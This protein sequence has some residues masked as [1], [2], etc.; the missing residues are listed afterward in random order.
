MPHGQT[1]QHTSAATSASHPIQ[2]QS[3]RASS[4]SLFQSG[5]SPHPTAHSGGH[6]PKPCVSPVLT[7]DACAP[8]LLKAGSE[9]RW[10]LFRESDG[11]SPPALRHLKK[12][13]K[14]VPVVGQMSLCKQPQ[15]SKC[16]HSDDL[17]EQGTRL[18][19]CVDARHLQRKDHQP[20]F[21]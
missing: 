13:R 7:C 12:Q 20:A 5:H 9:V 4:L 3:L 8:R 19:H 11:K 2:N 6:P 10:P 14:L 15:P 16:R 17:A 1:C 21:F 18:L